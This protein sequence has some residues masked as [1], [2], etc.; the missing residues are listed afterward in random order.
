MSEW[1]RVQGD[2]RR[3]FQDSF[4]SD[5]EGVFRDLTGEVVTRNV[6]RKMMYRY[7]TTLV[8]GHLGK[9]RRVKIPD[10]VVTGIRDMCPDEDGSYMGFKEK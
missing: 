4:F 8:H 10:C 7:Y 2:I 1:E 6:M 3:Y 5:G 9:G